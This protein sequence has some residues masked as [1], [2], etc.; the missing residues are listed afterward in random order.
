MSDSSNVIPQAGKEAAESIANRIRDLRVQGKEMYD[1]FHGFFKCRDFV[2][3]DLERE[4]YKIARSLHISVRQMGSFKRT[5][6]NNTLGSS[7]RGNTENTARTN[8]GD[9]DCTRAKP[10]FYCAC[11]D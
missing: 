2:Y 1:E 4:I 3:E 8:T 10:T 11:W 5:R 7:K 9:L 6:T